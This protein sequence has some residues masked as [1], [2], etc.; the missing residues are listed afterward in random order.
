M[1]TL[2]DYLRDL[3]LDTQ[4]KLV[5][6]NTEQFIS[7]KDGYEQKVQIDINE[8]APDEIDQLV[9]EAVENIIHRLIG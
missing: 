5:E 8:L 1:T 2:T 6:I 3:V 7:D 4:K 9:D